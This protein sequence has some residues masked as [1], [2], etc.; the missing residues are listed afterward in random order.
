MLKRVKQTYLRRHGSI[1]DRKAS[2]LP[3][4]SSQAYLSLNA[5]PRFFNSQRVDDFAFESIFDSEER[6]IN[7]RVKL[8][9]ISEE[10]ETKP[11]RNGAR[12]RAPE[13]CINKC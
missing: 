1:F 13:K 11:H 9:A 2:C 6:I 5:A 7:S 8:R 4:Q 10:P 3:L 12:A